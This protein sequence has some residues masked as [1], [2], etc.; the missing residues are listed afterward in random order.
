MEYYKILI[1]FVDNLSNTINIKYTTEFRTFKLKYVTLNQPI[2]NDGICVAI[3]N[4]PSHSRCT[5]KARPGY[6]CCGLHSNTR[7][8][9]FKKITDNIKSSSTDMYTFTIKSIQSINLPDKLNPQLSPF[10]WRGYNCCID[11]TSGCLY[12][13]L[14]N[15][16]LFEITNLHSYNPQIFLHI[17]ML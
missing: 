16:S 6:D 9:K 10:I 3:K 13:K 4:D 14:E 8:S 15:D 7:K 2:I 5:R 11:Y 17:E 12:Y 1:A